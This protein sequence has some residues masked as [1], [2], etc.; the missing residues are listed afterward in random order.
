[1]TVERTF[2]T[3]RRRFERVI[4]YRKPPDFDHGREGNWICWGDSQ[5]G[6]RITMLE[7]GFT[8]L[9]Q[10]G[11]IDRYMRDSTGEEIVD[12]AYP[13]GNILR[14]PDGPS[15]FPVEQILTYR[16][17]RRPP[18]PGIKF[19]QLQGMKI[20]EYECPE[21]TDQTFFNAIHLARHLR[22]SHDYEHR[23]LTALGQH[24]GID[25]AREY[26]KKGV[27]TTEIA[28]EEEAPLP[29]PEAPVLPQV[30]SV[31][32]KLPKRE[33]ARDVKCPVEGCDWVPRANSKNKGA[34]VRAHLM[35]KHKVT[36][37]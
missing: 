12:P 27:I 30:E 17:H 34:S 21:C 32:V 9:P 8:P 4:Y 35:H 7:R 1:V 25:F 5:P 3:N 16:W 26:R 22:N 20:V 6:K 24:L 10:F 23:D 19:P 28:A 14:H 11:R 36:A 13:W 2:A 37:A 33:A 18:I 29:P 15:Q 31:Q